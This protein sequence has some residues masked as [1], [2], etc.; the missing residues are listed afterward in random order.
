MYLKSITDKQ[1][2]PILV[3]L[4][5]EV[6]SIC[7]HVPHDVEFKLNDLGYSHNPAYSLIS[8][9]NMVKFSQGMQPY[10]KVV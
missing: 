6:C 2:N 5:E 9:D 1:G 7:N 3:S 4:F 8:F 10:L